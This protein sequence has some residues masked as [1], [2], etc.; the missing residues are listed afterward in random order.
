MNKI[1]CTHSMSI[2]FLFFI[3]PI[4]AMIRFLT[5][6]SWP[7]NA[8]SSFRS[9]T[10][11]ESFDDIVGREEE[12]AGAPVSLETVGENEQ[13]LATTISV[14]FCTL[15]NVGMFK[16]ETFKLPPIVVIELFNIEGLEVIVAET[17]WEPNDVDERLFSPSF[18]IE[19]PVTEVPGKIDEVPFSCMFPRN[20][21]I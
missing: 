5:V 13:P 6:G 1:K 4:A 21:I 9:L 14:V 8:A 10:G 19:K 7:F 2:T 11:F 12:E 17:N 18:A 16:P 15:P 20:L 3:T